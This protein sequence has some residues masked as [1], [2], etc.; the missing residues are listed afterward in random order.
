MKK[1]EFLKLSDEEKT[2]VC[3]SV[4]KG[5]EKIEEEEGNK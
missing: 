3:Q 2:K 4:V 1:E 5:S